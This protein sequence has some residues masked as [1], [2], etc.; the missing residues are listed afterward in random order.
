MTETEKSK[1]TLEERS[2]LAATRFLEHK[3][4]EILATGYLCD[5]GMV[6]IV[7]RDPEE[8]LVAFVDVSPCRKKLPNEAF[9]KGNR[10]TKE[11]VAAAFL[12]ENRALFDGSDFTV[13]FDAIALAVLS[14]DRALIR[15]HTNVLA[16]GEGEED[17]GSC[18]HAKARKWAKALSLPDSRGTSLAMLLEDEISRKAEAEGW[19]CEWEQYLDEAQALMAS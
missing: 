5:A 17:A 19:H 11:T 16:T 2:L 9:D 10:S 6:D 12:T 7:A 18:S 8:N 3:G 1:M 14:E 15:Y 4:F 13:R